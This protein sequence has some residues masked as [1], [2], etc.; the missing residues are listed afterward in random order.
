[1]LKVGDKIFGKMF[2]GGVEVYDLALYDTMKDLTDD[3]CQ[4]EKVFVMTIEQVGKVNY[5]PAPEASIDWSTPKA[6][7]IADKKKK[8]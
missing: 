7:K 4:D 2:D 5:P 3:A 8:R 6:K 1:M